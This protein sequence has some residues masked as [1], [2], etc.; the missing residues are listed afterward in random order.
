MQLE[1]KINQHNDIIVEDWV[2]KEDTEVGEKTIFKTSEYRK[3]M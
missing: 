2:A 1:D 3:E